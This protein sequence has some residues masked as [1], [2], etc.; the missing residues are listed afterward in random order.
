MNDQIIIIQ[1][2]TIS[3]VSFG[4]NPN[5]FSRLI[6]VVI[7]PAFRIPFWKAEVGV[8]VTITQRR[9]LGSSQPLGLG[10]GLI[11]HFYSPQHDTSLLC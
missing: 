9:R 7:S 6:H 8:Y 11:S 10:W 5:S 1:V 3:K 2:K 4:L